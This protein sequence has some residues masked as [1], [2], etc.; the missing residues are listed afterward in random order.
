MTYEVTV[1]R[2]TDLADSEHQGW[3]LTFWLAAR[4]L[5]NVGQQTNKRMYFTK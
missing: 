3:K 5:V 2:Y 1:F 4:H